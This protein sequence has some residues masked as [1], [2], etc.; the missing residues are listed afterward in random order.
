MGLLD[1]F[2][3]NIQLT[4]ETEFL[5]DDIQKELLRKGEQVP[6]KEI[7]RRALL[8]MKEEKKG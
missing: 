1:S 8:L 4:R 7:I 2:P 3:M 5:L 6:K